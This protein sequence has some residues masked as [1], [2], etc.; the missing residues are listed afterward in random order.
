MPNVLQTGAAWLGSQL[1]SHA[2]R[3]ITVIQGHRLLD[4][5][6]AWCSRQEYTIEDSEG[7]TTSLV[8]FDWQF[9]ASD[10]PSD[11]V[12]RDGAILKE[13]LNGIVQKYEAMP[14]G[15]KGCCERLDDAGVL[16]TVHTKQVL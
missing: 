10:L 14:L 4:P 3:M 15:T 12:F 9:V 1:S 11:F 13:T 7:F 6:S 5:L 2:V 8:S 16:L